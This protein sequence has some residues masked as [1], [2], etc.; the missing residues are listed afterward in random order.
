ML[1]SVPAKIKM[2]KNIVKLELTNP[3]FSKAEIREHASE[4]IL[5]S[6]YSGFILEEF[7]HHLRNAKLIPIKSD[8]NDLYKL[9]LETTVDNAKVLYQLTKLYPSFGNWK[10]KCL[11][12]GVDITQFVFKPAKPEK[13]KKAVK[14]AASKQV[15]KAKPA[16]KKKPVA[17]KG[18]KKAAPKKKPAP[19]K[20][21][22][23]TAPKKR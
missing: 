18:A 12:P 9:A 6:R 23:K 21:A 17:K 2:S 13:P 10:I 20:A 4:F 8:F 19:K 16:A 15:K 1:I 7:N 14:K 22:K 11:T 5:Y 3:R